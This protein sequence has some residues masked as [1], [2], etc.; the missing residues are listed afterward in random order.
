MRSSE[1]VRDNARV[2]T[3]V[4]AGEAVLELLLLVFLKVKN[5]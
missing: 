4:V 3:G 2:G 5:N 1:K